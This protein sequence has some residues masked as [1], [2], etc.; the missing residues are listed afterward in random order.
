MDTTSQNCASQWARLVLAL[1]LVNCLLFFAACT[2]KSTTSKNNFRSQAATVVAGLCQGRENLSAEKMEEYIADD[3]H[4][5]ND[6]G[7][8]RLYDRERA[9]SMCEWEKVMHT[10]WTYEI[11]G[12]NDSVVTV[13]LKE[14]NDYYTL[15]GLGGSIQVSEYTVSNGKVQYWKS[16]LFIVEH[17][18]QD[19][20]FSKFRT[21]LLSQPGLNEP[22]L[23]RPDS[24]IIFSGEAAPR[25]L[26]W[27]KEWGKQKGT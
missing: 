27:L 12:V 8:P 13:M 21:W 17:G 7:S 3:F 14:K 26:H 23:V 15:L 18:T 1:L 4:S 20:G 22:T 2:S 6:D 19:E 5:F 25:M 11:L 16:K 24:S 9:K 10:R